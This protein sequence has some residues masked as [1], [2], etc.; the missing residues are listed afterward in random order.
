LRSS[1]V[2]SAILAGVLGLSASSC[3]FETDLSIHGLLKNMTMLIAKK[4][5]IFSRKLVFG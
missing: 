4:A 3:V 5:Y 2:D 1:K